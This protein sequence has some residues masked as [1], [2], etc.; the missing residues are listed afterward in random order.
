MG[1]I[2]QSVLQGLTTAAALQSLR[3]PTLK[4]QE[5]AEKQA[6]IKQVKS[7][8]AN[9]KAYSDVA[10]NLIS[11]G[12]GEAAKL[13][14]K[15]GKQEHQK[16]VE[17]LLDSPASL[18]KISS[19]EQGPEVLAGLV[20]QYIEYKKE[21]ELSPQREQ[22]IRTERRKATLQAIV[23]ERKGVKNGKE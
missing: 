19:E 22:K 14:I 9:M 18:K 11:H 7:A 5:V 4:A 8:S 16:I 13:I 17:S 2:Q 12:D 15:S 3:G 1:A 21:Q 6:V 20:N 23:D 10:N